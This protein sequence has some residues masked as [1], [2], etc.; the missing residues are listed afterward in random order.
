MKSSSSRLR[1]DA[2]EI[3]RA[4]LAAADAGNAVRKHLSLQSGYIKAGALRLPLKNFDRIFLIAVGKAALQMAGMA[5]E[6]IGT[7]LTRGIAVT[8]RGHATSPLHRI[9][10]LETRHPIP[11]Q[12]GAR[13][14][15]VIQALLRECNAR[16]LVLVALSGGASALCQLQ[17]T[18]LAFGQNRKRLTSCYALVPRFTS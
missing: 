11:D 15:A 10:I 1:R 9:E 8:K 3:F 13:A 6:I 12:A 7:R 18:L 4:A 17:L 5:E 16:D 2:I 14:S